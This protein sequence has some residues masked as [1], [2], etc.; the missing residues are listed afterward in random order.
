MLD[1]PQFLTDLDVRAVG[2]NKWKLLSPVHYVT[3]VRGE[4]QLIRVDPQYITDLSSI[5]WW[6]RWAIPVNDFHRWAGVVHDWLF[7]TQDKHDFSFEEV[8][9]IFLEAM[10]IF[11][12]LE[13]WKMHAMYHAV[14]IGSRGTWNKNPS[15]QRRAWNNLMS[16]AAN[17]PKKAH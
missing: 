11:D 3:F 17:M 4:A 13:E 9:E 16:L 1:F 10:E 15:H 2:K 5:P 6:A 8:N 14:C 7:D 12:D